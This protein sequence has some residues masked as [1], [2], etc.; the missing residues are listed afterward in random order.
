MKIYKWNIMQK[1]KIIEKLREQN[2]ELTQYI[3]DYNIRTL[4]ANIEETIKTREELKT[5]IE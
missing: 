2:R 3:E 5:K 4:Q 1:Q